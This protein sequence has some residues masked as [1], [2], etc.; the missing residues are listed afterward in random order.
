MAYLD[1]AATTPML[2]ESLAALTAAY[3]HTGNASS[4]HAAGRAARKLVEESRESIA[5]TLGCRP[6]EVIFTSGGT[7]S[8]NLALKGLFW[9]RR[10]SDPRR[11]R[12]ITSA[13]EHHAV[14]DPAVWLAEHEGAILELAPV[15]RFGRV[16]MVAL[17]E[18]IDRD[19]TS[20]ALISVMAA[21]N[22]V[23]TIQPLA[24]IVELARPHGIPVHSDGVQAIGVL[25][26]EFASSGLDALSVSSHKVGGPL[27]V[28]A[29]VA[30]RGLTLE[31][32][33]HGG[34]Q[35]RSRSGTLDVPGIAGFAAAL[36]ATD[37]RRLDTVGRV[38]ALRD[39]LVDGVRREIPD[40]VF[41]GDPRSQGRL[42]GNAHFSFPGCEGDALLMLL[43]ARGVE[44][45]TGSACTAGIPEPSHV[46]LAMGVDPELA[47][48]SLRFSLGSAST[49]ADVDA[50]LDALPSAVARAR[51]A[52]QPRVRPSA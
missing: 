35:E 12:V 22:E 32:L 48:G 17:A 49:I 34:S 28:G 23:G 11:I 1:H 2:P 21:N 30:A 50:V 29:L 15:D 44:C 45:S 6:G 37:E 9:A 43:D 42:P 31:P 20:V 4:L 7:E 19:P 10:A 52:G 3:A 39:A 25:D 18:I 36:S 33:L 51:R 13:I 16:D 8:D 47:R 24:D 27:G 41:T 26:L 46:L 14:L 38:S 40:A 5:A